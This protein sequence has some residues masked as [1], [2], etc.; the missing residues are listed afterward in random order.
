MKRSYDCI[1]S[2][3]SPEYETTNADEEYQFYT[4][5][6]NKKKITLHRTQQFNNEFI[7]ELEIVEVV[8]PNTN[9]EFI[10][11]QNILQPGKFLGLIFFG[12]RDSYL[13]VFTKNYGKLFANNLQLIG[14]SNH[15]NSNCLNFPI[16]TNNLKLIKRNRALDPLGGGIYPRDV[17]ILY[18][19]NGDIFKVIEIKY[20]DINENIIDDFLFLEAGVDAPDSFDVI[21]DFLILDNLPSSGVPVL[22]LVPTL[23]FK[24]VD[25]GTG[26]ALDFPALATPA[27]PDSDLIFL[28]RCLLKIGVD[29]AGELLAVSSSPPLSTLIK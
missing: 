7:D 26:F 22:A 5:K 20:W 6:P 18:D 19:L 4:S 27:G 21:D 24:P 2:F 1:A 15:I 16:I 9:K 8:S 17:L 13:S 29:G 10:R 12:I 3:P 28:P 25:F 14:V 23:P 11:F